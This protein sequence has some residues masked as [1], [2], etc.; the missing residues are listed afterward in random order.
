MKHKPY[1]QNPTIIDL[2]K[3]SKS[4]TRII[5]PMSMNTHII[6]YVL[7]THITQEAMWIYSAW[8]FVVIAPTG[9]KG[10]EQK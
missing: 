10:G 4:L 5:A 6:S 3:K 2:S 7:I 1:R 8:F 9:K